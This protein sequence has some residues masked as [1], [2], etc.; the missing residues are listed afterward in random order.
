M[1]FL[2][3]PSLWSIHVSGRYHLIAPDPLA[4]NKHELHEHKE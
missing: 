3:P 1:G 2:V 4:V